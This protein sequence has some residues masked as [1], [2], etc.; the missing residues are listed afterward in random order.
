VSA[1]NVEKILEFIQC[2]VDTFDESLIPQDLQWHPRACNLTAHPPLKKSYWP[3]E[4]VNADSA[5]VLTPV[6]LQ[7]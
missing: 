1:E 5:C 3:A 6:Q 7:T 2:R 4:L